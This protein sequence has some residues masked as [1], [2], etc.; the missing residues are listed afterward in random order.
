M[1]LGLTFMNKFIVK[2]LFTYVELKWY[3]RRMVMPNW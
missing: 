1:N 2:E 3:P